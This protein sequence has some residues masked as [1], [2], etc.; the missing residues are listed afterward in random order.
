MGSSS[1]RST[2]FPMGM[3][4]C[5][6]LSRQPQVSLPCNKTSLSLWLLSHI[7][8]HAHPHSLHPGFTLF[9]TF[10]VHFMSILIVDL[11]YLNSTFIT[12][13]PCSFPVHPSYSHTYILFL[14]MFETGPV[15]GTSVVEMVVSGSFLHSCAANNVKLMWCCRFRGAGRS[16]GAFPDRFPDAAA[17]GEPGGRGETGSAIL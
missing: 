15:T 8:P 10:L 14:F 4:S 17:V 5:H 12:S 3:M 11:W 9:F 16:P 6:L 13:A 2:L 1:I 7:T